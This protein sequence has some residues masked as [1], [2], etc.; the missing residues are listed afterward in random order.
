M[1]VLFQERAALNS[2]DPEG[3]ATTET[4]VSLAQNADVGDFVTIT[5]NHHVLLEKM[6]WRNK[7]IVPVTESFVISKR[8]PQGRSIFLQGPGPDSN[9]N[10]MTLRFD[11]N[12]TAAM[13]WQKKIKSI[14]SLKRTDVG[15]KEFGTWF[16]RQ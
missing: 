1:A 15:F 3:R 13:E 6:E 14:S 4:I 9:T 16:W 5:W 7:E 12:V 8:D 11:P 2:L 10:Q